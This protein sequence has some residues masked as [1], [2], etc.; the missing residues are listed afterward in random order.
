M[1]NIFVDW[2]NEKMNFSWPALTIAG[3]EIVPAG[4][5][6]LFTL[7]HIPALAAGAVIPPN[8]EFLAMLGDQK[9]GNNIEMPEA[10]LRKIMRE[11]GGAS[12]INLIVEL[13]G[14]V[15]YKNQQKVSRRHGT[16][17]A[18]A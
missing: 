16:S 4:N 18:P 9:S 17:L 5:V 8:Q 2:I 15:V 1:F 13:D 12:T 6:Q 3:K 10:L 7:P 11:E 14:E